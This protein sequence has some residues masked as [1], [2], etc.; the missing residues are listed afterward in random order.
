[1]I[2]KKSLFIKSRDDNKN[3]SGHECREIFRQALRHGELVRPDKCSQCRRDDLPIKNFH[4]D[5]N[6]PLEVTWV[7]TQCYVPLNKQRPN[8]FKGKCH[9]EDSK[10][11]MSI[12]HEGIEM[13]SKVKRKI[14]KTM[15][16]NSVVYKLPK[17]D[18]YEIGEIGLYKLF[19]RYQRTKK[20]FELTIRH[21]KII[22]SSNCYYCGS[23][24]AMVSFKNGGNQVYIYN[25]VDRLDSKIG[26]TKD[27]VVP[28]CAMCNKMKFTYDVE[29]FL[30]HVKKI[31]EYQ[32]N[33]KGALN[34]SP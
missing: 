12:S 11:S 32:T 33:S 7:C 27:N 3:L 18:K 21:F 17:K 15:T 31:A 4:K 9:S 34:G 2:M 5:Y 14:S 19:R 1:M 8:H 10:L 24:P 23:K 22:T 16:G 25:G 26:Y 20:I 28:C 13:S 6:K 30:T 29:L